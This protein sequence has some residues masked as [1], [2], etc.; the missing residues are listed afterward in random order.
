MRGARL[1]GHTLDSGDHWVVMIDHV[2]TLQTHQKCRRGDSPAPDGH[3]RVCRTQVCVHT[4]GSSDHLT[5]IITSLESAPGA[6]KTLRGSI[7]GL[8]NASTTAWTLADTCLRDSSAPSSTIRRE[9]SHSTH[10]A[11]ILHPSSIRTET[12]R[13]TTRAQK[14]LR[15]L[16]EWSARES[17]RIC[18]DSNQGAINRFRGYDLGGLKDRPRG[19]DRVRRSSGEYFDLWGRPKRL[20]G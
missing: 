17:N 19:K 5:M 9:R 3:Q 2:E 12:A 10:V 6:P 15:V 8:S 20:G 13:I 4:S 11:Q 18:G 14:G 7:P 16:V 1:C